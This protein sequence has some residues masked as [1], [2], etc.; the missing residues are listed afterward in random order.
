MKMCGKV[1]ESM[2]MEFVNRALDPGMGTL[3]LS[4]A[5]SAL[6]S[7]QNSLKHGTGRCLAQLKSR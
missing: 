2:Y 1:M 5:S 4:A 6:H 7:L 3:D